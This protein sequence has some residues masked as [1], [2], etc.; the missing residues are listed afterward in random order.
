MDF[1]YAAIL[2]I[3]V[4][5]LIIC[6]VCEITEA[7]YPETKAFE[8]VRLFVFLATIPIFPVIF[9]FFGFFIDYSMLWEFI[10]D[11][12]RFIIESLFGMFNGCSYF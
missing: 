11:F 7:I 9:H 8:K 12:P 5:L 4:I 2:V 6:V 3:E 1:V 10:K